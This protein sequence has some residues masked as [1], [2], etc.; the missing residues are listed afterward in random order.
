MRALQTE[1][2]S[3]GLYRRAAV[4]TST[5]VVR[6]RLRFASSSAAV[7]QEASSV[8]DIQS[9]QQIIPDFN[10]KDAKSL[11][12][13]NGKPSNRDLRGNFWTSSKPTGLK[14]A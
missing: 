13:E 6:C 7:A 1:V 14:A 10:S 3:V 8:D 9:Q 4:Y 12:N 2:R 11:K 5:G